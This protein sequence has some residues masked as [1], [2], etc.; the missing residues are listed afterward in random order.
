MD[1]P[2]TAPSR[3][4]SA[5]SGPSIATAP[6]N[7][8]NTDLA[9]WAPALPFPALLTEM[10]AAGYAATEYG[11]DFPDDP[12]ALADALG[13]REMRLCG[14]YHGLPLLDDV[15]MAAE[16]P[17]LAAKLGLLAAVGC[18]DLVVAFALTPDRIAIAGRVPPD[19]GA[20]LSGAQWRTAARHLSEVADLASGAGLRVHFH[21][22]VGSYVETPDEIDRFWHEVDPA[23]VDL[24]FDA[25][26]YAY[27][28]G[29]PVAFVAAHPDR[30]GYVHLKD[31]D[32]AVLA[33]AR[34][35]RLGFL[36]ALR[37]F[38]FCELGKGMVDVPAIVGSLQDGGYRGWI[39][40]EQDTT[41]RPPT[42]SARANRA[43]LR[44]R[45]GL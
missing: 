41:P 22:H 25:G 40:V 38:V 34:A 12:T 39:V 26:H 7:W 37:T 20:G 24:C 8:N 14:A 23:L 35:R 3:P 33:E 43:Y 45:C 44:E 18:R 2:T 11:A 16:C 13:R 29:D 1:R 19:G 21:N 6:V 15:A 9:D 10:A 30:I 5:P 42:E 17:A 32:A 4:R 28:G 36:D 27:G 31:V